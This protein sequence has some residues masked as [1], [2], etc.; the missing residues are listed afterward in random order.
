MVISIQILD[1][2]EN[3]GKVGD[4]ALD[5]Y[6]KV[7]GVEHAYSALEIWNHMMTVGSDRPRK[8]PKNYFSGG[9]AASQQTGRNTTDKNYPTNPLVF[10]YCLHLL[11]VIPE[12]K[13]RLKEMNMYSREWEAIISHWQQIEETLHSETPKEEESSNGGHN[14]ALADA[15]KHEVLMSCYLANKTFILLQQIIRNFPK[16][17]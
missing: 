1:S 7:R 10:Y 8:Y 17:H 15:C 3:V 12:W 6:T 11:K 13:P 16:V 9:G 4:R 5:W 2:V 14:L